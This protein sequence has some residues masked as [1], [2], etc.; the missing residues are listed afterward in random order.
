MR[1]EPKVSPGVE[2]SP[3][4]GG[5]S[6]ARGPP[7]RMP[8]EV[9][10]A[11]A[12]SDGVDST[13]PGK[14]PPKSPNWNLIELLSALAIVLAAVAILE[15]AYSQSPVPPGVDPGDWLQRSFAFVGLPHPPVLAVGSPY[16]YPPLAFPFLGALVVATGS[17]LTAGFVFGGVLLAAYG[18]ACIV[19]GWT[20]LRPGAARPL[21]VGLAV[22]NGTTLSMLFW[23]GYPNVFGFVFLALAFVG[24]LRF[25]RSPTLENGLFMY[26]MAGLTYLTHTLSFAML[27]VGAL[28]AIVLV[29]TSRP[30][31]V[32][33]FFRPRALLSTLALIVPAGTYEVLSSVFHIA[34]PGYLYAN[35]AALVLDNLGEMFQ[36]LGGAP[37]FFPSG[38]TFVTS[39][40]VVLGILLVSAAALVVLVLYLDR[41]SP[42]W[43]TDPIRIAIGWL[44]ATLVVPALGD[45]AHIGTDYTR[46]VY[47]LPLPISLLVALVF[48]RI[49]APGAAA[50][51]AAGAGAAGAKVGGRPAS[52]RTARSSSRASGFLG[53]L[54]VVVVLLTLVTLPVATTNETRDT[55][56]SHDALFV[57]AA[58]WLSTNPA[59]G[60]VLTTSQTARWIE[61]ISDR[62]AFDPGPTWLL[63]EP[64]QVTNAE[65]AYWALNG[66][67]AITNNQVAF[68]FSSP[69]AQGPSDSP[70]YTPY[71]EGVPIPTVRIDPA[72]L[73]LSYS[74]GATSGNV[75]LDSA[76]VPTWEATSAPNPTAWVNYTTSVA[77]VSEQVATSLGGGAG[78]VNFTVSPR[79]GANVSQFGFSLQ[80]PP[81]N[82]PVVHGGFVNNIT[83]S[84]TMVRWNVSIGLGQLP[85]KQLIGSTTSISPSSTNLT[86]NPAA[87]RNEASATFAPANPSRPFVVSV[88]FATPGTSNPAT[89][90]PPV[91]DTGGFLSA[92]D[93]GFALLPNASNFD[94]VI[95]F[96]EGTY[97]FHLAF[98]N[99][100]WQ[101]LSR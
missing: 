5:P 53:V 33:S 10:P 43:L 35:P 48:E 6:G 76:G 67:R 96:L 69:T 27:I 98:S 3:A 77:N 58:D 70:I 63:F 42:G 26:G 51:P 65:L 57:A 72:S 101:V 56:H 11:P 15:A 8:R 73:D 41:R 66:P 55:G 89:V 9:G 68:G 31:V 81:P 13:P 84:G 60:S 87:I 64:W 28:G 79:G 83:A 61:A 16:L 86:I 4:A 71:V 29:A 49:F 24:L 34:H 30:T 38:P 2:P 52:R 80:G 36:P 90:L 62:G 1:P 25:L 22:L 20:F 17:P 75:S 82:D 46:F 12:G 39:P 44:A 88:A 94:A 92:Y 93:I 32:R 100:E 95:S 91:M 23:G 97:G 14:A 85:G 7:E 78:W 54:F 50:R 37:M 19:L 74:Q 47:F 21:F 45:L 59:P 40:S 99:A 18:L